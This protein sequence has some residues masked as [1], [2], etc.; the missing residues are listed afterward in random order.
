M[1]AMTDLRV[2]RHLRIKAGLSTSGKHVESPD[3][4]APRGLNSLSPELT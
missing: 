3:G 1:A 4:L 2:L